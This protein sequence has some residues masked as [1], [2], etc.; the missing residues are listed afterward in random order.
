MTPELYYYTNTECIDVYEDNWT[1][2]GEFIYGHDYKLF[3]ASG[4]RIDCGKTVR[5]SWLFTYVPPAYEAE[6]SE[7]FF[8][9]EWGKK[10]IACEFSEIGGRLILTRHFC[11]GGTEGPKFYQNDFPPG[12]LGRFKK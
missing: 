11:Y 8:E 12:W 4:G 2:Y 3:N 5:G 9:W 6:I 10:Y 7:D 1:S